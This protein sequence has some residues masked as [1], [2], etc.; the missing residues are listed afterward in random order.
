MGRGVGAAVEK[1]VILCCSLSV[2]CPLNLSALRCEGC[3]HLYFY[4][5]RLS[6]GEQKAAGFSGSFPSRDKRIDRR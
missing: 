6:L 1:W 5:P 4:G 3:D 2:G